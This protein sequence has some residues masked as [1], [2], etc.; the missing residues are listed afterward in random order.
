MI[1]TRRKFLQRLGYMMAGGLIVPCVP[2]VFYSIPRPIVTPSTETIH[3]K[4]AIVSI[5]ID[6]GWQ[7]IIGTGSWK[8][9]SKGIKEFIT[10]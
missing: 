1:L 2:K 3:G 6:G 10:K 4:H 5:R 8:M 7:E 9:E